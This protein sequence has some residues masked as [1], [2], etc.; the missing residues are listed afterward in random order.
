MEESKIYCGDKP[1]LPVG[2]DYDRF[3]SRKEC[4]T[5]GFGAAMYKYRWE[6]ADVE[7]RSPPRAR[8]GCLRPN[9]HA[10]GHVQG[11]QFIAPGRREIASPPPPPS[12]HSMTPSETSMAAQ[13]SSVP[14]RAVSAES[15]VRASVPARM[16]RDAVRQKASSPPRSPQLRELVPPRSRLR[17]VV[18]LLLWLCAVVTAFVLLYKIPPDFLTEEKDNKKV[19]SWGKFI[20]FYLALFVGIT[21]IFIIFHYLRYGYVLR[22]N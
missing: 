1:N 3:G 15:A 20:G 10:R 5:C 2:Q 13:R 6:P 9:I 18:I 8:R 7:P 4:L 16:S 14:R 22:L 19:I 11:N 21:S 17:F 12:S